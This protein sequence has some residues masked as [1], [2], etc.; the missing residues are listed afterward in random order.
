MMVIEVRVIM[1]DVRRGGVGGARD[2]N[3]NRSEVHGDMTDAFSL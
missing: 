2:K 1:M 3:R